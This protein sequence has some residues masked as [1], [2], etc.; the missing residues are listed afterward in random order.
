VDDE[1]GRVWW[2]G[3]VIPFDNEPAW[4][5]LA[6]QLYDEASTQLSPAVV[7]EEFAPDSRFEL[8]ERWAVDRGLTPEEGS[9]VLVADLDDHGA[10]NIDSGA[11]PT[12]RIDASDQDSVGALHEDLFPGTHMNAR[13]LVSDGDEAHVRLVHEVGESV[14]GY[15]AVER[16]PDGGGYIDFLGVAP[17]HRNQ[18]IGGGLI[19]AG[20]AQLREMGCSEVALTVREGNSA[21]RSIYASAGFTE[22]RIIRPFRK[23][24]S[25][26]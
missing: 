3:P 16:Q 12:R 24:F 14:A 11:V 15:I 25:L 21:A 19:R 1:I 4:R 8:L 7:Q 13:Q 10:G 22:E 2:L 23:G 26:P 9:A 17:E 20:V 5:A 6:D 18:G